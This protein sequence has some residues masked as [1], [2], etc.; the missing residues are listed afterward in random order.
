MFYAQPVY[1]SLP[2]FHRCSSLSWYELVDREV[3][4]IRWIWTIVT[5]IVTLYRVFS[6]VKCAHLFVVWLVIFCCNIMYVCVCV[7][8]CIFTPDSECR[9]I[10]AQI[11]I[12]SR[13]HELILALE[14]G[15]SIPCFWKEVYP[16]RIWVIIDTP[17]DLVGPGGWSVINNPHT[18]QNGSTWT[19][20]AYN[21]QSCGRCVS[22]YGFHPLPGPS[23][24]WRLW[25]I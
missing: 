6:P 8:L 9:D 1:F 19:G 10:L 16:W 14:R 13:C 23:R 5:L 11:D 21:Q 2:H 15:K 17:H 18:Q 7:C 4:C 20:I 12:M 3:D 24:E 22:G 25:C